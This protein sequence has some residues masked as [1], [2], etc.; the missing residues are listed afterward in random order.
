MFHITPFDGL[1]LL[2]ACK[3]LPKQHVEKQIFT[4]VFEGEGKRWD[5]FVEWYLA[6]LAEW[7]NY[8]EC[9]ICRMTQRN[10]SNWQVRPFF[11]AKQFAKAAA[12]LLLGARLRWQSKSHEGL[13]VSHCRLAFFAQPQRFYLPLPLGL[14]GSIDTTSRKAAIKEKMFWKVT[15]PSAL[16]FLLKMFAQLI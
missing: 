9:N 4:V 1:C 11:G 3:K 14:H 8:A 15:L 10:K 12:F 13:L 16:S 7:Y 2:P 5:E 6:W